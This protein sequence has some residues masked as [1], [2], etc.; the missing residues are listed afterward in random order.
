MMQAEQQYIDLF[1]QYFDKI[2]KS[3]CEMMN[4][5][6]EQAFASFEKSGFPKVSQED[7][8][9]CDM[10]ELLS[11]DYGINLNRIKIQVNPHEVFSCDVPNLSTKLFFVINDQFYKKDKALGFP[12]GVLCGSLNE[13]GKLHK[14]ILEKYYSRLSENSRDGMVQFNTSFAQDGIVLYVPANVRIEKPIQLIQILYGHEDMLVQRRILVILEK[15]ASAKLLFCDHSLSS[16]RFFSNQVSEIFLGEGAGLEY[17]ELEMGHEKTTRVSNTF[18]TLGDNSRF[19]HNGITLSNGFTRN[20]LN[21]RFDGEHSEA[22][23]S[24]IALGE[25]DQFI[26]NHVFV[27]HAKPNCTSNE[28][29]KYVLDGSSKGIFRGRILVEKNAQKTVAY[30][31]NKNLCSSRTAR[32]ISKP[33]LEIYADDVKCSHGSATGQMDEEKLFYIRSRGISEPEARL[34][35]KYAFT[36]DVIDRISLVPLRDRI[37][38][39]IEKR[40]RGELSKCAGCSA[41]CQ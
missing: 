14:D 4:N 17:Y 22:N 12:E 19:L 16:N 5:P 21:V 6:R 35:L 20:N 33:Q 18:A 15:G 2:G 11:F 32:M 26:D 30:Q 27:N 10:N 29:Y 9:N 40:F 28:L 37:R 8:R 39:L 24:G 31:S 1:G 13:F 7:Y 41:N 38:L 23:L 25:H 3:C 34:L 36:S